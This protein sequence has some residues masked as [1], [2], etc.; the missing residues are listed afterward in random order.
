MVERAASPV[1]SGLAE[2]ASKVRS[3]LL[4]TFTCFYPNNNEMTTDAGNAAAGASGSF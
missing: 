1:R 4:R 3:C 2:L